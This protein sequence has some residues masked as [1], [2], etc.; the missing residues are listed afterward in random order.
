MMED[1]PTN[2][3]HDVALRLDPLADTDIDWITAACQDAEIQRWTVVP[4]PYQRHHA[5][6][7]V[8]TGAG[9]YRNWAVRTAADLR[10]V[11]MISIHTI[12]SKTRTATIGYW[13][14]PWGRQNGY[15]CGAI[16]LVVDEARHISGISVIEAHIAVTNAASRRAVESCGFTL[17]EETTKIT[18]PDG[19]RSVSAAI[20]CLVC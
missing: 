19:E 20:Y 18:C 10:P 16:R 1:E 14:A 2:T 4:R 6:E 7:F 3:A 12:D 9:E 13:V 15:A 8:V 11:G 17:V 5:V